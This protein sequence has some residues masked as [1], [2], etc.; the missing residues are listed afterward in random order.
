MKSPVGD[1]KAE[2]QINGRRTALGRQRIEGR[3]DLAE[4]A[5]QLPHALR[6]RDGLAVHRGSARIDLDPRHRIRLGQSQL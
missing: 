5:R 2:G 1:L 4:I 6:L 3:I